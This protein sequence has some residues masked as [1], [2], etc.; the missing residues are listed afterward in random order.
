MNYRP[1]MITIIIRLTAIVNQPCS[2]LSILALPLL[3]SPLSTLLLRLASAAMANNSFLLLEKTWFNNGTGGL[4]KGFG[5]RKLRSAF[6]LEGNGVVI[7]LFLRFS[8]EWESIISTPV[9]FD[10][11]SQPAVEDVSDR[12]GFVVECGFLAAT[13]NR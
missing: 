5:V 7:M 12:L 8:R 1:K 9:E 6:I 3:S 4:G 2:P 11:G 13:P 10:D